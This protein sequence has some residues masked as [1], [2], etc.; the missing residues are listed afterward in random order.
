MLLTFRNLGIPIAA[1]KTEGPGTT[2]EFMGIIL[3][4]IRM[5]ARL[6]TDKVERLP[7]PLSVKKDMHPKR[8]AVPYWYSELCMQSD[9]P[10]EAFSTAH[11]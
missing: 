10:W 5:E 11:D 6:P 9:P 8:V 7:C 4:T 1:N 3:D 2:F